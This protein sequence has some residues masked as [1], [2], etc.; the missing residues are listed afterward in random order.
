MSSLVARFVLLTALVY[1]PAFA[2]APPPPEPPKVWTGSFNA[3]LALTSG[4]SDTST[5][6]AGYEIIYDRQARNRVKSD[7][8]FLRGKT[9]GELTTQRTVLNARDEYRFHKRAFFFGQTQ[10]LRDQFKEIQY[11]VAPTGGIGMHLADSPQTKMSVD[12]GLGGVWEKNTDRELESSGAFSYSEKFV[13]QLTATTTL[14][15]SLSGLHRLDDFENALFQAGV[16]L[17]AGIT[18]HTQ[19]KVEVLNIY[20]TRPPSPAIEKN[21]VAVILAIV[22]KN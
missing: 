4:N 12:T 13:H 22:Y 16:G 9:D 6:N 15:E 1:S 7:G 19:L 14:T 10:Y 8:L 17:G 5:V 2:Q 21:D 11:L 3:G 18:T 20:K